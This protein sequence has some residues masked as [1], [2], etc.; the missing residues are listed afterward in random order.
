M[1]LPPCRAPSA[2]SAAL[3][4]PPKSS[5][6]LTPRIGFSFLFRCGTAEVSGGGERIVEAGYDAQHRDRI[7]EDVIKNA[8][9]IIGISRAKN[10]QEHQDDLGGGGQLA[11]NT[12]RKWPVAGDE[13]NHHGHNEDQDVPA[14]NKDG[15]PPG[16]LLLKCEDEEG[17]REQEFGGGGVNVC[18]ESGTVVESAVEKPVD[19]VR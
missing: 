1:H 11:V 19:S 3:T 12:G 13:Q 7:N 16:Q 17:R 15:E 4:K 10:Y 6:C 5:R 9:V 2:G 18:T 8:R 14:E